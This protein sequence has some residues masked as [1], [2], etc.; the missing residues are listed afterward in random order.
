MTER[1]IK[2]MLPKNTF[3]QCK[4]KLDALVA[5][6]F[7][8]QINYYFDTQDFLNAS[9]GNTLRVR[10]KENQLKLQYKYDKQHVGVERICKEFESAIDVLPPCIRS[11]ELPNSMSETEIIFSYVGNL[12]TMR[13]DYIYDSTVI[14]LDTNYYLGIGDYEIEIEFQDHEKTADILKLLSL[15]G[16]GTPNIGKYRR[17]ANAVKNTFSLTL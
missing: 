17:F 13:T 2:F 3:L 4:H 1:E 10:Q 15:D 14:S 11:E 5:P 8:L 6:N 12:V 9:M 7:F 16:I